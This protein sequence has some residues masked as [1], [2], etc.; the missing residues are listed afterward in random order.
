MVHASLILSKTAFAARHGVGVPAVSNWIKRGRITGAAL[1]E[2]G[3]INVAE[4]ERQLGTTLDAVRSAGKI[5]AS[6][7]AA[8]PDLGTTSVR[9]QILEVDLESKR[10]KLNAERGV[11]CRTDHLARG[12]NRGFEQFLSAADIWIGDLAAELGLSAEG[13]AQAQALWRRFREREAAAA[14]NFAATLPELLS[15]AG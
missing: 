11:Y 14:R 10:R 15:D 3:R 8:E 1:T 2:D 9:D 5:A 7:A 4:A 13:A 12:S 6:A